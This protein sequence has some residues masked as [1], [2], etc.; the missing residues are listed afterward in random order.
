LE[1]VEHHVLPG[2]H[3]FFVDWHGH[4]SSLAV[5]TMSPMNLIRHSRRGASFVL[6]AAV[7]FAPSLLSAH[8]GHYH[9]DETDEFDFLKSTL[10]HS[11]GALDY[12]LAAVAL[13][14]IA[15]VCLHGRTPVRISALLLAM[16]S[17]SLIPLL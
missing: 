17:L 2:G 14:S 15:V 6:S 1:L 7:C 3:G 13:G 12:L 4:C 9:P 8:P 5:I 10:L 16:G 11:H